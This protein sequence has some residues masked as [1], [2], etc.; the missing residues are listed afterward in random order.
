MRGVG[1]TAGGW[2]YDVCATDGTF[3]LGTSVSSL[4]VLKLS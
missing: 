4:V 2:V 3:T 1:T